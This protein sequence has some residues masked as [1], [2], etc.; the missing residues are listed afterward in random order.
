[1][2]TRVRS[3]E[4]QFRRLHQ[5]LD[6]AFT[7]LQR[8][9]VRPATAAEVDLPPGFLAIFKSA[10]EGERAK[11]VQEH[12][13][14]EAAISVSVS[15][16]SKQG[17]DVKFDPLPPLNRLYFLTKSGEVVSLRQLGNTVVMQD[18][19][20]RQQTEI[21]LVEF[22]KHVQAGVWLLKQVGTRLAGE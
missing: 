20:S 14:I 5:S 6:Q 18:I 13:G 7:N 22:V 8:Q 10:P 16:G 19:D 12:F 9:P 1:V 15:R 11:I 4:V 17:Y 21:K 3:A 2:R